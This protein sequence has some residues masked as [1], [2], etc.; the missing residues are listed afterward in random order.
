MCVGSSEWLKKLFKDTPYEAG[1]LDVLKTL[2][3]VI[4]PGRKERAV[5][6]Y[7]GLE[8]RVT[9]IPFASL[10]ISGF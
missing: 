8:V 10:Q 3:D 6:F 1:W 2:P 7:E 4:V 9:K 5:R